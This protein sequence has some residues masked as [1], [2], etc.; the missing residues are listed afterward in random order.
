MKR[1]VH[2]DESRGPGIGDLRPLVRINVRSRY[3]DCAPIPFCIDTGADLSALPVFLAEQ[4][5]I[6]I[7]KSEH[8]R[9]RVSGLVGSVDRYRGVIRLRIFG[10][11]FAWPC[12]F[13]ESQGPARVRSY[14]VL[15]RAGLI[16]AFNV[17]IKSPWLTLDRR[18]DHLPI[19][20]RLL[21][22]LMPSWPRE[23]PADQ[24]L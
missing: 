16:A 7:P 1:R 17:C 10:E 21:L 20:Q 14:G 4:R 6:A 11:D 8:S 3:G 13:V 19:W 5:G 2:L 23:H 22:A 15:G 12:D 9:G 18:R 24:P